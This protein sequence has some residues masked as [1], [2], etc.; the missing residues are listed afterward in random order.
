MKVYQIMGDCFGPTTT[1]GV[2]SSYLSKQRA[3]EKTNQMWKELY[4]FKL[5]VYMETHNVSEDV[6]P[7]CLVLNCE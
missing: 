3:E 7:P 1:N 4:Q 6:A 2:H 5:E